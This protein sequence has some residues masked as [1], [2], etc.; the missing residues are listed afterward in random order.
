MA[1]PADMAL[2]GSAP[3]APAEVGCAHCGLAARGGDL[4]CCYGC[5]LAAQIAREGAEEHGHVRATLLVSLLLSMVVM[6]LSLFLFSEDVYGA[7]AG[8]ELAWLRTGYRFASGLLA[9]P[10]VLM[11]GLPVARRALSSLRRARLSMDLLVSLGAFAAYGISVYSLVAGRHGVYFDSAVSALLLS[12]LGRYLEARGRAQASSLL[13]PSLKRSTEPVMVAR[14]GES[15]FSEQ[16]PS[17]VMPGDRL[18]IDT[19]EVLPVDARLLTGPADVNLGVLTGESVPVVKQAGDEL[20][21]GAIL[22]S[23]AVEVLALRALHDSTLERLSDLAKKLSARPA[24]LQRWADRFAAAMTPLVAVIAMGTLVFH[25]QRATGEEGVIAALSVVLAA[26]PCTYGVATPLV[27]WLALRKALSHGAL[28]RNASVL[29]DLST[30]RAVAF[31]KTGTLTERSLSVS[32]VKIAPGVTE[33]EVRA[34]VASLE[35]GTKHPVGRA[36]EAYASPDVGHVPARTPALKARK[37]LAGRGVC[38]ADL[39]G[40]PLLLGSPSWLAEMG[41]D[42]LGNAEDCARVRVALAR[43]GRTIAWFEVGEAL[44]PEAREAVT[45]LADMGISSFM[46]TGDATEGAAVAARALGIEAHAGLSAEDKVRA[47]ERAGGG[48]AMVGDGL[49]DAP[50]LAGS[51]TSFAVHGGTDLARG[52]AQV[53][54]LTPDLRLVPWTVAL[55]RRSFSIA[56]WNL[57]GSTAYNLIFLTLAATGMLKPVWAGL[58]MATSSLLMIASALRVRTFP[59]PIGW[60]PPPEAEE[61]MPELA[62]NPQEDLA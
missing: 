9:T 21:A 35:Q 48:V 8:E 52:M 12:T 33:P 43:D 59:P 30:V 23:G 62:A 2:S 46:L 36:L 32:R 29:E 27:F 20:P 37:H 31:D 44:K 17:L 53:S 50:A 61:R 16:A 22:V 24:S 49:N 34:L 13:G 3:R 25:A 5:E 57:L 6:M 26:C 51:R 28:V 14:E 45:A 10:V 42:D 58:S 38:G 55:A 56:R 47:L 4:Y 15:A 18:R 11:L 7:S 54:L 60:E 41:I 19:E 39:E 40:R 1:T